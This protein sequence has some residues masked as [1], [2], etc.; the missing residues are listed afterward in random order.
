MEVKRV[1]KTPTIRKLIQDK[2]RWSNLTLDVLKGTKTIHLLPGTRL[3]DIATIEGEISIQLPSDITKKRIRAP[4]KNKV[5]QAGDLRIKMKPS[6]NGSVSFT[7]SGKVNRLLETRALNRSG[8]YLQSSNSMSSALF[9]G[10]GANK[11]KQFRET[12]LIPGADVSPF[13]YWTGSVFK[14]SLVA[15]NWDKR[16]SVIG[17]KYG[18]DLEQLPILDSNFSTHYS[19]KFQNSVIG[20]GLLLGIALAMVFKGFYRKATVPLAIFFVIPLGDTMVERRTYLPLVGAVQFIALGI[21]KY[22]VHWK[23]GKNYKWFG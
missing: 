2:P 5:V 10:R 23:T 9:F 4:F 21:A 18:E 16:L 15:H 14:K 19:A 20:F 12:L 1:K 7:A 8:K 11:N 22:L 3:S 17:L 13:Y 6:A